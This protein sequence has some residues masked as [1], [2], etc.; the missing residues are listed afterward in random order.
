VPAKISGYSTSEPIAPP[1]GSNT[2][3][4]VADKSQSDATA[5]AAATSQTGDH[6]TLTDSARSLQKL[7]EAIAQAPVVNATK[8]ASIKQAVNGGT[9]KVDSARVADK[10]LQFETGLK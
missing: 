9:Y 5:A 7:S 6:V 4:V 1:K 10:M 8:V 2:G 3:S